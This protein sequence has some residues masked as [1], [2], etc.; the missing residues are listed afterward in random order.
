MLNRLNFPARQMFVMCLIWLALGACRATQ[1]SHS[2]PKFNEDPV[3]QGQLAVSENRFTLFSIDS[4]AEPLPGVNLNLMALSRIE[5][6]CGIQP[7]RF[8]GLELNLRSIT[9]EQ[10]NFLRLYNEVVFRGCWT[11]MKDYPSA[12][13]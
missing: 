9:P 10:L 5:Q 2:E 8:R 13:K 6:E 3:K 4:A 7:P 11:F 12:R 1:S